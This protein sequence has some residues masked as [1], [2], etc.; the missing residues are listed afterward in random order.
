[1]EVDFH[2][3]LTQDQLSPTNVSSPLGRRVIIGCISS[4]LFLVTTL[5]AVIG[6]VGD[7]LKW[8]KRQL[9]H[10]PK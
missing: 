10:Q 8:V 5:L 7:G 9:I 2:T 3:R 1:M 6:F 4:A